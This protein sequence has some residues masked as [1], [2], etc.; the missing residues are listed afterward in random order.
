MIIVELKEGERFTF[1]TFKNKIRNHLEVNNNELRYLLKRLEL[2]HCL[3]HHIPIRDIND[4][5]EIDD[6]DDY[7]QEYFKFSF[8][9]II[10]VNHFC[11]LI[12]PKYWKDI[13][14]EKRKV[15]KFFQVL[16]VIDKYDKNRESKLEVSTS[17]KNSQ[18]STWIHILLDYINNG[19]YSNDETREEINGEGLLLWEKTINESTAY[20]EKNIPIYLDIFTQST[21]INETN[22]IRR[23]HAA[24]ISEIA[25]CLGDLLHY[26]GLNFDF[27]LSTE[28]I[29]D[30]GT[31]EYIVYLLENE[32]SRQFITDKQVMIQNMISYIEGKNEQI[33]E[34]IQLFGT[35][36]FNMVWE[37]VCSKVYSNSLNKNMYSLGLLKPENYDDSEISEE[38]RD[39]KWSQLKLKD[40]VEKP[41]WETQ[42]E[43][44]IAN[45]SLI[46]DVLNT[47][48]SN[49]VFRI[50]DAK[51]YQISFE[52]TR[53]GDL[54]VS[55]QP[56]IGDVT[57]QYLY[58][59]AYKNLAETNGYK[60]SNCFV[61]PK[62]DLVELELPFGLGTGNLLGQV[63]M[64][65]LSSLGLSDIKVIERDCWTIFSE[66]LKT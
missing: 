54:R 53:K 61:V 23:L 12:Y 64:N 39:K 7:Q 43:K 31:N 37:A 27:N 1:W 47:D 36:A 13:E 21:V 63:R 5:S 35:T 19:L 44:A 41:I 3:K 50:Y 55:G 48:E 65:M 28:E 16:T 2:S 32:L 34:N 38:H 26:I 42:E 59:L 40:F 18:L 33:R 58:Q 66:Y 10:I 25:L 20:V 4:V 17:D 11:F 46:L 57:K 45:D 62:D 56:G 6:Y 51:Y 49:K 22:I 60:F 29:N 8:V 14:L 52:K 24:I 9:G 30:F 15:E